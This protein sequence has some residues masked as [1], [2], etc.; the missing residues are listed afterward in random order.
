NKAALAWLQAIKD[1]PYGIPDFHPWTDFEIAWTMQHLS[2]SGIPLTE[3]RDLPV[4][5]T[6]LKDL[7]PKGISIHPTYSIRDG[8]TTSV[9]I[10]V[11]RRAG[12]DVDPYILK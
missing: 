10:H 9:S 1:R 8:D 7:T 5:Q 2:Y 3:F 12:F 4:W 11:L 6:L